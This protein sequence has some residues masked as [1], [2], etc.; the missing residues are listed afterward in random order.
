MRRH[1]NGIVGLPSVLDFELEKMIMGGII[2]E[3]YCGG[4]LS[5]VRKGLK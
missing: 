2:R 1:L 5:I 3:R 4:N